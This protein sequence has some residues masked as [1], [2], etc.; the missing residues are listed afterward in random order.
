MM[1]SGKN[2]L[3][4]IFKHLQTVLCSCVVVC[5][6]DVLVW[7]G[8]MM[9]FMMHYLARD[10]VERGGSTRRTVQAQNYERHSWACG[11]LK[12]RSVPTID[13]NIFAAC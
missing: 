11:E 12:C 8:D 2:H 5:F 6:A 1:T 9:C 4:P 13:T 10:E 3:L 7:D